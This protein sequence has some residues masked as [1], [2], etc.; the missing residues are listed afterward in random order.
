VRERH[1]VSYHQIKSKQQAAT[2]IGGRQ[3]TNAAASS[4][5][6][7][8][9]TPAAGAAMMDSWHL[10]Q[11]TKQNNQNEH[12]YFKKAAPKMRPNAQEK[13][14]LQYRST[15][16]TWCKFLLQFHH[17]RIAPQER[18]S[19]ECTKQSQQETRSSVGE[20]SGDATWHNLS[21][22]AHSML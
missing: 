6:R 15:S 14:L 3:R 17:A 22:P 21:G 7:S 8:R 16:N 9:Q 13:P 20:P 18:T 12:R 10:I 4:F 19:Q 2:W 5:A 11:A 1:F